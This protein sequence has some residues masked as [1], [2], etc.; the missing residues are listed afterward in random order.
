MN[1]KQ[2]KEK[3][4]KIF[5]ATDDAGVPRRL[6]LERLRIDEEYLNDFIEE[7]PSLSSERLSE[8]IVEA[9]KKFGLDVRR[10]KDE[11]E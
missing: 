5:K 1:N 11:Q 3:L 9:I 6:V 8:L 4:I 7:L 10:I 2:I